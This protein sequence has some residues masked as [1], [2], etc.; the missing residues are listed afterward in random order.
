VERGSAGLS[1]STRRDVTWPNRRSDLRLGKYPLYHPGGTACVLLL[2]RDVASGIAGGLT[3]RQPVTRSR[4]G[5]N[6]GT[7]D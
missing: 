7:D 6:S 5:S 3:G 4:S 1:R 2:R